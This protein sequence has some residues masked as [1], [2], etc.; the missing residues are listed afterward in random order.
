M[1]EREFKMNDLSERHEI[2]VR[3]HDSTIVFIADSEDGRL[4]IRQEQDGKR[5]CDVCSITL[6]DPE[7]LRGFFMGLRRMLAS[8]GHAP[9]PGA[10]AAATRAASPRRTKDQ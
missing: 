10:A 3:G 6:S 2:R 8:L 1:R 4:H 9:E 7:E 5:D